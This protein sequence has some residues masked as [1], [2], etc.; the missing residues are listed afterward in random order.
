MDEKQAKENEKH[1][2]KSKPYP[3]VAI[4]ASAGGLERVTKLLENLPCDLG[5]AFVYIQ[6]LD[7]YHESR[8]KKNNQE[9]KLLYQDLLINVTHFFRDADCCDYL[10]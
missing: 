5:M 2:H 7:R 8:L 6:H 10:I 9:V 4:G 3:I 1:Q